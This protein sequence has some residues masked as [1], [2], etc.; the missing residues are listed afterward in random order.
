M[1]GLDDIHE[2]RKEVKKTSAKPE[3]VLPEVILEGVRGQE[4]WRFNREITN[5]QSRIN[6][7]N[8]VFR[9]SV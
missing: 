5:D 1:Y 2:V 7:P 8:N 4:F 6:T 9:I 3:D